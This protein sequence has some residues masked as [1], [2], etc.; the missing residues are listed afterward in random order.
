MSESFENHGLPPLKKD[1]AGPPE[2]PVREISD[3]TLKT[4]HEILAAIGDNI[5]EM[6]KESP[7]AIRQLDKIAWTI[8]KNHSPIEIEQIISKISDGKFE[9]VRKVIDKIIGL[10]LLKIQ[11]AKAEAEKFL[12]PIRRMAG[13]YEYKDRRTK[14]ETVFFEVL[15]GAVWAIAGNPNVPPKKDHEE[16]VPVLELFDKAEWYAKNGAFVQAERVLLLANTRIDLL[17]EKVQVEYFRT[18]SIG[19]QRLDAG[20]NEPPSSEIP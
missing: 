15:K 5:D 16:E 10:L 4:A 20:P 6:E 18:Q 3:K 17:S 9:T 13:A 12:E 19:R 14:E 11:R 8:F 7:S 1:L 2:A